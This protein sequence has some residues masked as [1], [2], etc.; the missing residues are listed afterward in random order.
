MRTDEA[1][2]LILKY[3][4]QQKKIVLIVI[5]FRKITYLKDKHI[6]III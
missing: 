1:S 6:R 2:Y 3:N 4:R 5:T